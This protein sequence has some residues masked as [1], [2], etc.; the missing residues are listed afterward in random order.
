M[1]SPVNTKMKRILTPYL[2]RF[3]LRLGFERDWYLYLVAAVIGL[4]MGFAAVGFIWPLRQSEQLAIALQGTGNFWLLILLGPAIGGLITGILITFLTSDGVGPGVTSVIYAVQRQKGK[5]SWKIGLRKWLASTA[6][7]GSGGSTVI[8][9]GGAAGPPSPDFN[10]DGSV[11]FTDFIAFAGAF[12]SQ[13]GTSTYSA[14]FDLDESGDVGFTDF[15]IF[16]QAFG[17]PVT[18]PAR[19][20]KPIGQLTPSENGDAY[21][22]LSRNLGKNQGEMEVIVKVQDAGEII[23]YSLRVDYDALA[24]ELLDAYGTEGSL[25]ALKNNIAILVYEFPGEAL[26]ADV[27]RSDAGIEAQ[28]ELARL[29]FRIIDKKMP[30]RVEVVEAQLSDRFGRINVL[31]NKYLLESQ[32]LP[33]SYALDQNY[34][35]PFNPDTVIP[36]SLPQS[37][38]VQIAIH[39][40]LGQQVAELVNG[41]REAGFHR[42]VWDGK[43]LMGRPTASGIYL[44]RMIS[45]EFTGVRKV[46]FLK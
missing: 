11:D 17:Q 13:E 4:F 16:A 34:P 32:V 12:G 45:G 10:G 37:G 38:E 42:V 15:L 22:N 5:I 18:R 2:R 43:D 3:G 23:G 1:P 33:E 40:I 9:G 31:S 24:L 28:G 29:R 26:L 8:I 30:G 46:L 19:L 36:F 21:L 25:F 41:Y 44:V 27:L 6:T 39:N 20:A 14:T 7:I 35:N